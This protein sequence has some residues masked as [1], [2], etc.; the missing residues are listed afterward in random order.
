MH[1]SVY[2]STVLVKQSVTKSVFSGVSCCFFCNSC[3][4]QKCPKKTT[5][6]KYKK[7]N[8]IQKNK[9]IQ[10]VQKLQKYKKYQKYKYTEKC[11]KKYKIIQKYYKHT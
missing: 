10:E 4:L 7:Y 3:I 2:C 11:N 9:K 1:C 5:D 8:T 6:R